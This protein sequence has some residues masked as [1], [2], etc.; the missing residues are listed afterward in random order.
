[1]SKPTDSISSYHNG[2]YQGL[3]HARRCLPPSAW[4]AIPRVTIHMKHIERLPTQYVAAQETSQ[5]SSWD[6]M[7]PTSGLYTLMRNRGNVFMVKCLCRRLRLPRGGENI[8]GP[9]PPA[10]NVS[11]SGLHQNWKCFLVRWCVSSDI[12]ARFLI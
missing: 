1:M 6:A 12:G 9:Q 7:S 11:L 10:T 5:F 4:A 8:S 3:A 2:T